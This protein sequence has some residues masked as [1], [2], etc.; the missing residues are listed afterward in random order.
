[1]LTLDIGRRLAD[2]G[3]M[4]GAAVGVSEHAARGRSNC[5]LYHYAGN[6]PIFYVD[7]DGNYLHIYIFKS[8]GKMQF[9]YTGT[10]EGIP[11]LH[12]L[13][14]INPAQSK[15][16]SITGITGTLSVITNVNQNNPDNMKSSDSERYQKNG[17]NPTQVENGI[18]SIKGA[19]APSIGNGKYGT[20]DLGLDI[21]VAQ[22][23]MVSNPENPNYGKYVSDAGYMIHIT[24]LLFTD[25]CTGINYDI[26]D[27]ES[28]ARAER[29]MRLLV[30]MFYN[31]MSEDGDKDATIKFL[32]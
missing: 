12:Y 8:T 31:T 29:I 4:Y 2:N 14:I 27:P 16:N 7:P 18:Y 15:S 17:T 25:G 21:D 20:G 32:D 11:N 19:R 5:H 6:N 24:P 9:V 22:Q 30:I 26:S 3:R 10:L 28:K 13:K 23:L 1:M